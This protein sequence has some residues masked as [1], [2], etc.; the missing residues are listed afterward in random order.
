MTA[1]TPPLNFQRWLAE[2]RHLLKPPVSNRLLFR[3]CGF[4]VQVVGGP[5]ARRD[6]HIDPGEEFFYQIE[7]DM[8]IKTIQNGRV[9]DVPLR[10][11]EMFLLPAWMPHSPRRPAN[12]IGLVI[13]RERRPDEQDGMQWFCEH[14]DNLLHQEFFHL[15]NMETQLTEAIDRFYSSPR[16]TTCGRCGAVAAR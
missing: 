2:N 9:V 3:D 6:F 1:P 16:L 5:N 7:G 11:G 10:E 12:T 4:I 8:V 15:T 14:C 13:E